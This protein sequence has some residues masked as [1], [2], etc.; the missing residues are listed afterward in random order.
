MEFVSSPLRTFPRTKGR[1]K[2]G[3]KEGGRKTGDCWTH[4]QSNFVYYVAWKPRCSNNRTKQ[5]VSDNYEV[6]QPAFELQ[7]A[8]RRK[9]LG[10]KYWEKMTK[11]RTK[12]FAS[13]D[14]VEEVALF[15]F[16]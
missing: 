14:Q 8:I 15:F 16:L 10:V 5:V 6:A 9:V 12:M 1:R 3:E 13:F 2:E 4:L 11:Q 7:K